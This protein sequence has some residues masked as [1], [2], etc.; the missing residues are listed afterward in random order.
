MKLLKSAVIK[1]SD[2]I[3][4]F[5]A[6]TAWCEESFGI[7]KRFQVDI[8]TRIEGSNWTLI[9]VYETWKDGSPTGPE[10][11][12]CYPTVWIDTKDPS[13]ETMALLVWA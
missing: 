5:T 12:G 6:I 3:E 13:W 4:Q 9:S 11:I 2:D 7:T 1:L 8:T 10:W